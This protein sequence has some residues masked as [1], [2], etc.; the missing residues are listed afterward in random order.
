MTPWKSSNDATMHHFFQSGLV[1]FTNH[2]FFV[3]K[4]CDHPPKV[5]QHFFEKRGQVERLPGDIQPLG[6][7]SPSENGNGT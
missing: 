1:G 2:H 6:I 5:Q 7:Q 3:C 4:S